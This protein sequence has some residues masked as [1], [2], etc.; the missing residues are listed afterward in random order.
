MNFS[1][2]IKDRNKQAQKQSLT[3]TSSS[4]YMAMR[5]DSNDSMRLKMRSVKCVLVTLFLVFGGCAAKPSPQ[6]LPVAVRL[7]PEIH[8]HRTYHLKAP[9]KARDESE[10][11]IAS[12]PERNI[13]ASSNDLLLTQTSTEVPKSSTRGL[14]AKEQKLNKRRRA[15][16]KSAS[17]D[18]K[19]IIINH[20]ALW[21]LRS[22]NDKPADLVLSTDKASVA[23]DL[24]DT[25]ESA[26]FKVKKLKE[27]PS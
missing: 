25:T 4:L 9:A 3:N 19:N 20:N 7:E 10:N 13:A 18:S 6:F 26:L 1:G 23:R 21:F 8:Q 5:C 17:T 14:E 24:K 2:S 11:D 12:S 22:I 27:R 15:K 16:P